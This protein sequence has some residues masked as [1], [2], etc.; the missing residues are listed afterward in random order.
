MAGIFRGLIVASRITAEPPP[1]IIRDTRPMYV[2]QRLIGWYQRRVG[3]TTAK[4]KKN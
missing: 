4:T 3:E 1:T 2:P